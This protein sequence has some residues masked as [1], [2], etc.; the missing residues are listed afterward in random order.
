MAFL[1]SFSQPQMSPN[2]GMIVGKVIDN[3]DNSLEYVNVVLHKASDSSMID[4]V[5][6]D[7]EGKFMFQNV[8]Y[9]NYY[10]EFKFLGFANKRI[11]NIEVAASPQDK[12]FVKIGQ[13][14]LDQDAQDIGD[15]VVTGQVT[16]VSYQI[17]KKV[18]NVG[19]DISSAGGDATDALRNVPSVEVDVNGD[20]TLRGSS[21][22]TVMI[23]GKPSILDPNEALKQ[24]PAS[25][26]DKIE[27][28]TNPSAKY[29]PDGDAGIINILTKNKSDDGFS[30]KVE[31]GSDIFLG[32]SADVLLNYKKNKFNIFTEVDINDKPHY[33]EMNQYRKTMYDTIDFIIENE[34]EHSRGRAGKSAKLGFNYFLNDYNTITFNLGAGQRQYK[35]G[36]TA[37][38]HTYWSDYSS[39]YYFINTADFLV[40]GIMYD[41]DLNFEHKFNDNGHKIKAFGQYSYWEP[42]RTNLSTTDTVDINQNPL[43]DYI[44]QERTVENIYR[45][46]VRFQ[47]DYEL[48]LN[49]KNKF[50]AGY[51]FRYF[52]SG[53]DYNLEYYDNS[54]NDWY[55]IDSVYNNMTMYRQI[56]AAYLTFSGSTKLFNYKLGIRGEYTDRLVEEEVTQSSY[57]IKRFDYFPTVH[58]S[59]ELPFDQQIQL[60]YSKR[61][62][63]PRGYNLN[64]FPVAMDRYSYRIGNPSLEPEYTNSFELNYMKSFGKSYVS[65]ETYFKQTNGKIDRIMQAD[66]QYVFFT[67]Q[68]LNKDY[69]YGGEVMANL[70]VLK[71]LMINLST[72]LYQYHLEGTLDGEEVN[73]E[74][75]TWNSRASLMTMLPTGTGIQFGGYYNA[76]TVTIDG[77]RDAMFVTFAGVRQNFFK[78]KIQLAVHAHDLF[79][80][81]K[82]SFTT[83]TDILYSSVNFQSKLPN[84][85]FT[86]TYRINNYQSDR[87]NGSSGDND[88]DFGGEGMY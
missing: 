18:I 74:T 7:I 15:V 9:D 73:K 5:A 53:G 80:T 35:H 61:I 23:N 28:I 29:D 31:L 76:P 52:N 79:S 50:E 12:R 70:V 4:A 21:N 40:N 37:F 38:Q 68:N 19:Q 36:S 49:D 87:R 6:T 77:A 58:L 48:P 22:F 65:V 20:V 59:K 24:I 14:K 81:M 10:L 82:F 34:G 78:K 2:T 64:P 1:A 86:L 72:N 27:I 39:D 26:I 33:M 47:L 69:S 30:G 8:T 13:V 46:R 83:E 25:N 32:Y 11:S 88:V 63:R 44:Y 62:N 16:S 43:S 51:V 56:H 66:G 85:G 42:S 84:I 71:M 17:D 55:G 3:A 41:A 75:F 60:S 57:P 45:D 54:V 67:A